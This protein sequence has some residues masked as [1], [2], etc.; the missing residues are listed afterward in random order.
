M[1]HSSW[2][3]IFSLE[4]ELNLESSEQPVFAVAGRLQLSLAHWELILGKSVSSAICSLLDFTL[5]YMS[6][7][8]VSI[9]TQD[10]LP[11]NIADL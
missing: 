6:I 4:R 8:Y 9:Y 2:P 1:L 5:R 11:L 7:L 10:P 3:A